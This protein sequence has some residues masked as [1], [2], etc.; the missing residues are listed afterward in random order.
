MACITLF[1][2]SGEVAHTSREGESL[3]EF[4]ERLIRERTYLTKLNL[5]NLDLSCANMYGGIFQGSDFSGTDLRHTNLAFTNM[6]GT[7]LRGTNLRYTSLVGAEMIYADVT[8][9]KLDFA[10]L[11]FA[12]MG[13]V[14]GTP[15]G[16]EG[17][18]LHC[19]TGLP[20]GASA[21]IT[22]SRDTVT[23]NR[24]GTISIGDDRKT[25]AEW[26]ANKHKALHSKFHF[27]D[28]VKE[29]R[30]HLRTAERLVETLR[31]RRYK[32]CKM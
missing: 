2:L 9:A 5:R 20:K 26:Q 24:D 10:N 31:A 27:S 14:K 1:T 28:E 13:G 6:H 12:K 7:I 3:K 11:A 18:N 8:D 17:A 30:K 4:I 29:Y 23:I 32:A 16:I 21:V 25:L 22:G 15:A 19:V